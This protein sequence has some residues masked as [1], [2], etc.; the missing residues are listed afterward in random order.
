MTTPVHDAGAEVFLPE[1]NPAPDPRIVTGHH[2]LTN[3]GLAYRLRSIAGAP[4]TWTKQDK[5]SMLLLAADRLETPT[6]T[7]VKVLDAGDP[8]RV[9]AL[10]LLDRIEHLTTDDFA[11]GREGAEREALRAALGLGPLAGVVSP[12]PDDELCAHC[13]LNITGNLK[14]ETDIFPGYAFLFPGATAPDSAAVHGDCST[15]IRALMAYD[16]IVVGNGVGAMA[17]VAL[18]LT[19]E[20]HGELIDTAADKGFIFGEDSDHAH[21]V[22]QRAFDQYRVHLWT[23]LTRRFRHQIA[24]VELASGRTPGNPASVA[25]LALVADDSLKQA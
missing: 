8:V 12:L 22:T 6:S 20:A 16:E 17:R 14:V 18:D 3:E 11:L 9:A 5:V 1:T 24:E 19:G 4:K 7:E 23:L 2:T 10:A 21:S 13:G 15:V 25:V